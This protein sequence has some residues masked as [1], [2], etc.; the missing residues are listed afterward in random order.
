MEFTI[1]RDVC[2]NGRPR[3]PI[4]MP[5]YNKVS[6]SFARLRK[7]HFYKYAEDFNQ[8]LPDAVVEEGSWK[9]SQTKWGVSL[10]LAR[11]LIRGRVSYHLDWA[12]K[13]GRVFES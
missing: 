3:Q 8:M 6:T 5:M 7:S 1:V 2:K 10:I 4:K 13:N 12:P 11:S 9:F